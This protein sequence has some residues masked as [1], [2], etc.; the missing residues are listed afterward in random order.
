VT[1]SEPV[2]GV[3]AA[4]FGITGTG[5]TGA[6]CRNTDRKRDDVDDAGDGGNGDGTVGINMLNSTG[7]DERQMRNP[8]GNLP[9][10]DG[11]SLHDCAEGG[12]DQPC[13]DESDECGD[14]L[15]DGDVQREQ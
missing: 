5:S 4:N 1:F 7:V 14:G 6:T 10:T 9:F 11:E 12:L 8:V 2:T 15:V 13:R 3:T